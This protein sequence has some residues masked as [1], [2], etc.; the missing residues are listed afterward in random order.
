MMPQPPAEPDLIQL[1]ED[2]MEGL[3]PMSILQSY[4]KEA[5][6]TIRE[7]LKEMR[8]FLNGMTIS[9]DN[10]D[11]NA[12]SFHGE[13]IK[14]WYSLVIWI[15][16]RVYSCIDLTVISNNSTNDDNNDNNN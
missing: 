10:K 7:C 8:K 2:I 3:L 1:E 9:T 5:I 14:L 11:N 13:D 6:D 4:Q 16:S 15:E 12:N